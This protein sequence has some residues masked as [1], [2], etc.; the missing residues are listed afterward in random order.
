MALGPMASLGIG[1]NVLNWDTIN[2]LKDQETKWRIDPITKKIEKNMEKQKELTSLMTMMTSLNSNFKKLSDF[3]TYQQRKTSIEGSGV[4]ATAGE[5]LAIQDL[6]INV[7]QL[8]QNDVN[9]VGKEFA[10]RDSVFTNKNTTID[11]YH[12]GTNYSIDVKAGATLSE[13]SQSITDATDGDVIGIIMKT[14]GDNPYR[15]MIQSK[16][17]GKDNKI[18]FGSTLESAATP[19]GQIT[20]GTLKVEIGGKTISVDLSTIGSKIGNESKDNAQLILDKINEEVAKDPDLQSRV[21]IG[22]NNS[23]KGLMFN[24][25]NGDPIKVT[26]ENAK[27]QAALGTTETDTDLGFIKTGTEAGDLIK[28]GAVKSGELKGEITINGQKIDLN[29]INETDGTE[30]AKKVAEKINAAFTNQE[31]VATV[32]DGKLVINSKDGGEIRIQAEGDEAEKTKILDS[33]GLRSGTFTSS[34]DFLGEMNIT[35]I[36]KAQNA[37]FTYN[38]IKIERDKN[39]INDVVSGLS[40]ELTAVTEKDKDVIVRVA[41]DDKGISEVMEDFVKNYNEV[42]NKI[43]ELVK[44]DATT[45]VTGV[46]NG[47]SE[48]RSVIRQLNSIINSNDVNGNNLFKFGISIS[49]STDENGKITS[50]GTLKFDKEKFEKA[51][52]DDPEAAISFFRSTTSTVRGSNKEI[53]GVFTKLRNTMDGLITGEKATL[54]ALEKSLQ[55][56]QKT[57]NKDKTSTQE[58]IDTRYEIMASKW[59]AYDQLIAKTQQ[60]SNVV[61]QMIQQSMNS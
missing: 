28:G 54:N 48:M 36:Q 11:F 45:E 32:K 42:Y 26:V 60:Q 4:K 16:D 46:F 25:A 39:N 30:N 29:G 21:S 31:V 44:Y 38:G 12:K 5:G 59:S 8:A 33:I 47:N 1:S 50:S 58:S 19:G 43:Q 49:T 55:N 27:V 10:S 23:G 6:K 9:Q 53:D 18:Y 56:E 37:E 61:M 57:L 17:S 2:Q 24:D 35:N 14:G 7:S 40:L 51:Y 13:V 52:K 22:L 34:K 15:L 3:S 41:R 20:S